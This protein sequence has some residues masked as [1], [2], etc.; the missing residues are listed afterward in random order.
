M[1]LITSFQTENFFQYFFTKYEGIE[2]AIQRAMKLDGSWRMGNRDEINAKLN[3]LV[4]QP[5]IEV[6]S[7]L[8]DHDSNII[9]IELETLPSTYTLIQVPH[10]CYRARH[11]VHRLKTGIDLSEIR[12]VMISIGLNMKYT[13]KLQGAMCFPLAIYPSDDT[14]RIHIRK[15]ENPVLATLQELL[16][17]WS[18]EVYRE[19]LAD[20]DISSLGKVFISCWILL[21]GED[22]QMAEIKAEMKKAIEEQFGSEEEFVKEA[23]VEEGAEVLKLF[24]PELLKALTLKQLRGFA[25][26]MS[27]E[28]VS[29]TLSSLSPEQLRVLSSEQLRVLSSEQLKALTP[30]QLKALTPEQLKALTPEQIKELSIDQLE[31]LPLEMLKEA[32][33]RKEAKLDRT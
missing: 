2:E 26:I 9:P 5:Q 22:S 11:Y 18:L 16:T 4:R 19:L 14:R 28:Q 31:S 27:P 30:E 23:L 29:A 12:T 20:E 6:D 10:Y 1:K 25:P 13:E 17:A 21:L 7:G 15:E 33:R 24:D 8:I 32:I 3:S